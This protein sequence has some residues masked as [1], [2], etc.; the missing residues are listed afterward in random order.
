MNSSKKKHVVLIPGLLCDQDLWHYQIPVL[1]RAGYEVHVADITK[2]ETITQLAQDVLQNAPDQFVLIGLSM[3]GYVSLE[4]MRQ[5]PERVQKLVITNSSPRQDSEQTKRRRRGLIQM[6]SIG[7][8]KGV[9]P[10]LLPLLIH[11]TRLDEEEITTR[12]MNMAER[13]GRDAFE[14]QQKAILSRK[15][16]V[17]YL[18]DISCD[19]LLVGGDDDQITPPDHIEEM[20]EKIKGAECHIFDVCGHLAPLEYPDKFN[21]I[22]MDFLND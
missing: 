11:E 22:L 3:G 19:T 20:A 8:F 4:I 6:A 16:S 12:I 1:E 18:S 5:A 21:K 13:V 10:K 2:S 7:K 15:D 9:T 17:P 14:R